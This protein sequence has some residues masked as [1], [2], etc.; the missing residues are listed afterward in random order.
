MKQIDFVCRQTEF[1]TFYPRI[2]LLADQ[3]L[4]IDMVHIPAEG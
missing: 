3:T 4:V 2:P 1:K